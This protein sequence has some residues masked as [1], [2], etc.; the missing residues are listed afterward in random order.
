[1]FNGTAVIEQISTT[2][3]RITG[4]VLPANISTGDSPDAVGTIGFSN[5]GGTRPAPDL[6]LPDTFVPPSVS[7]NGAPVSLRALVKVDIE[8]E[9]AGPFT[10]LPPSIEKTGEGEDFRITI[11]NTKVGEATQTLEIYLTLLGQGS[12]TP[13]ISVSVQDSPEARVEISVGR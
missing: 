8:P 5:A 1:M 4:L 6:A 12:A 7:F 9:S 11:T 2:E 10:N 3:L 13:G